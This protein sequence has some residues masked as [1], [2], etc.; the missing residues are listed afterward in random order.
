MHTIAGLA[1][2]CLTSASML[3][4]ASLAASTCAAADERVLH[5]HYDGTTN[6]LLTAGLGATG[7]ASAT[8][9]RKSVV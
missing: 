1:T 8:P 3:A 4:L 6:D 7:L 2:T 9:D 5:A